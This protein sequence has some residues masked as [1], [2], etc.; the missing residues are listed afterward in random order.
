MATKKNEKA[1][2][3]RSDELYGYPERE[4]FLMGKVKL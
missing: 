2:A 3:N 4:L 1:V